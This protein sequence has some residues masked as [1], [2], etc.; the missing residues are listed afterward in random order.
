MDIAKVAFALSLS[1]IAGLVTGCNDIPP[2]TE[3]RAERY[4]PPQIQ[5]VG[6]DKEDLRAKTVI[7]APQQLRNDDD[8]LFVTVPIR[9]TGD[10]VLHTQYRVT[11]FDASGAALPGGPT[12][13]LRKVVQPGAS[14][15]IKFNSTT[16]RAV[17]WQLE[18]RY[19][20]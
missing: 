10:K 9:A 17:Q 13:W 5:L 19:A 7:D 15:P 3:G 1:V 8:L 2:Y 18:L 4:S 12:G 14:T 20:R 6:P 16:H 11:F